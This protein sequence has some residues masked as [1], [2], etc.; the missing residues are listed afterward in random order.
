MFLVDRVDQ[1]GIL[2]RILMTRRWKLTFLISLSPMFAQS[3]TCTSSKLISS[4]RLTSV[5]HY[6]KVNDPVLGPPGVRILLCFRGVAG[7]TNFFAFPSPLPPWPTSLRFFGIFGL[8]FSL[9]YLSLSDATVLTFLTPMCTAIVG[10]VLLKEKLTV[11][12]ALAGGCTIP[13]IL[14]RDDW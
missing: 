1:N 7:W 4:F 14:S 3:P 12:E 13:S 6:A 8:Y 10:S 2:S 5:R 11:R 9:Q